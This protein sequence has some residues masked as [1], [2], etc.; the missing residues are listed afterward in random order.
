MWTLICSVGKATAG[1]R[2]Y[3][4]NLSIVYPSF[5]PSFLIPILSLFKEKTGNDWADRADFERKPK[6]YRL[7]KSEHLKHYKKG[8]LD[9]NLESSVPSR[10]PADVQHMLVDVTN[11]SAYV[12]AYKKIGSDTDA[13]PFGR[14]K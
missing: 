4:L 8:E 14:I 11:I 12:D 10:L 2:L 1:T 3:K 6:K 7:V 13:V 9:F 5:L